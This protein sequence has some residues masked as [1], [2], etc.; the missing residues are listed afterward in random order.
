MGTDIVSA[1]QRF[2]QMATA[3]TAS[4]RTMQTLGLSL[5]SL[6][7]AM[8]Q[9]NPSANATA[10]TVAAMFK[11]MD[12]TDRIQVLDTALQQLGGTAQQVANQTFGGQWQQL[13]NAWDATMVQVGQA[14]LPVISDLVQFAKTDIVPFVTAAVAAFNQLPGPIKDVAVAAG[15]LTVATVPVT[16]SLAAFGLGLQGLKGLIPALKDLLDAFGITVSTTAAEE[17]VAAASTTALGAAAAEAEA[18]VGAGGLAGAAGTAAEAVGGAG[19]AGAAGTAAEAVGGAGLAG[20][21]GT[22]AEAVGGAGLAGAVGEAGQQL[23]L[24]G[25]QGLLE[26]QG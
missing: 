1:T 19:L 4:A 2:D 13:A 10:S 20:A 24:P 26:R 23:A 11:A 16:A 8:D 3:G 22:A 9:V 17:D 14:L 12:Q 7:T 18:E 21:A 15:L 5:Q 25:W 6:A